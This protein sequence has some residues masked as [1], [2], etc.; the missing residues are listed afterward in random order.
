MILPSIIVF[1]GL[2]IVAMSIGMAG[3]KIAAAIEK[4]SRRYE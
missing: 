3:D 1:I 4:R 2:W